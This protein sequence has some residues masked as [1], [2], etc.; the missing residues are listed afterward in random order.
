MAEQAEIN[1]ILRP[2]FE[3]FLEELGKDLLFIEELIDLNSVSE[4]LPARVSELA[5]RCHRLK[6]GAGFLKLATCC[7][8]AS[9]AEVHF[10]SL[11]KD[12]GQSERLLSEQEQGELRKLLQLL[13]TEYSQLEKRL[14]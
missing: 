8:V 9:E 10:L 4:D 11:A 1:D 13:R 5:E 6:G 14:Q 12:P 3:S 7:E 2:A